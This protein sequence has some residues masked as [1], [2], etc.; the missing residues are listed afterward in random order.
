MAS[1]IAWATGPL[2]TS[3]EQGDRGQHHDDER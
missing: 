2:T 3:A 1:P